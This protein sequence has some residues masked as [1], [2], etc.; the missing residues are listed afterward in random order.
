M[1]YKDY[2]YKNRTDTVRFSIFRTEVIVYWGDAAWQSEV[3]E[4]WD[5]EVFQR[6]GKGPE[7]SHIQ[8]GGDLFRTKRAAKAYIEKHY[9]KITSIN[10]KGQ[11]TK[12]WD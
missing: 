6:D 1:V 2:V 10:P 11:I 12:G 7:G 3:K 4:G 8:S 9:G 5:Y